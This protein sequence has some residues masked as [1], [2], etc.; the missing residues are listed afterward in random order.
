M[1]PYDSALRSLLVAV[2]ELGVVEI[3]VVAHTTCGACHMSFKEFEHHMLNRGISKETFDTIKHS[4]IDLD[5]WLEGFHDTEQSVTNTVA[6]IRQHPLMP[7]DVV[8]RGFIID[9]VTGALNE[10]LCD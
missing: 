4:G 3:M 7:R 6:T 8:V 2:Y 10:V 9:S 5:Q 1:Q